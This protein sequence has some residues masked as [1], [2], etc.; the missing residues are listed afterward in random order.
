MRKPT[1]SDEELNAAAEALHEEG[2]LSIRRLRARVGGGGTSRLCRAAKEV[3][4]AAASSDQPSQAVG[5]E[6]D[7]AHSESE[8]QMPAPLQAAFSKFQEVVVGQLAS[9]RD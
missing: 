7:G 5:Q 4:A 8:D 2:Q 3:R 9:A 6:E 1:I